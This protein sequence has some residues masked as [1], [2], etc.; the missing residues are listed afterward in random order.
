LYEELW[1][2]AIMHN[3]NGVHTVHS[4]PYIKGTVSS[5]VLL[6]AWPG[7]PIFTFINDSRNF[8]VKQ[9]SK[10]SEDCSVKRLNEFV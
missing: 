2:N 10:T 1:V 6:D 5:I 9:G 4:S 3:A 7:D 8:P